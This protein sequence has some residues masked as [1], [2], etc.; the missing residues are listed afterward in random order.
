MG[1]IWYNLAETKGSDV[2][3]TTRSRGTANLYERFPMLLY[4]NTR[5]CPQCRQFFE[6]RIPS[7]HRV[8]CS[9]SCGYRARRSGPLVADHFWS[10][11]D[12]SGGPHA[13]WPWSTGPFRSGYGV[14]RVNGKQRLTHRI[15]WEVVNGPIPDGLFVCHHCD[16]PPCC[17]PSHFFLGTNADNMADMRAKG[18]Q[19]RGQQVVRRD[20]RNC[21]RGE[22]HPSAKLTKV[23]AA[24]IRRRYRNGEADQA[25]LAAEYGVSQVS[26]S[27]LLSGRTWRDYE[28]LP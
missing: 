22:Q 16:N 27:K 3:L 18:R 2:A 8:Y 11:V 24:D 10:K 21:T 1:A 9:R 14:F 4:P 20:P 12:R 23:A 5:I 26:I 25:T 15:A 19:A 6:V 7:D 17:N 13:C 28:P